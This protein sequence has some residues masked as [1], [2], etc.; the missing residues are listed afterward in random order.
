MMTHQNVGELNNDESH[1]PLKKQIDW[2]MG[3]CGPH[4][5]DRPSKK[6][7]VWKNNENA[8]AHKGGGDIT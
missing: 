3:K 5:S 8:N 4:R 2:K 6:P 7:A 1:G